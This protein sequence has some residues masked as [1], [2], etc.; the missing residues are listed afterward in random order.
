MSYERSDRKNLR[1]IG[2]VFT[3]IALVAAMIVVVYVATRPKAAISE[4]PG[5]AEPMPDSKP[6][7]TPTAEE[8]KLRTEIDFLTTGPL[9]VWEIQEQ[10][11]MDE[12]SAAHLWY[13]FILEKKSVS[14]P[15]TMGMK[16][17]IGIRGRFLFKM[18]AYSA[19][20]ETDTFQ[21]IKSWN[22]V[23][24]DAITFEEIAPQNSKSQ[25]SLDYVKIKSLMHNGVKILVE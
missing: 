16:V 1:L 24:G 3:C 22:L 5:N 8:L 20:D 9:T 17:N 19:G 10:K 14:G 21:R 2:A 4:T 7:P 12:Y 11:T 15:D 6:A 23:D 13:G 18:K 25:I